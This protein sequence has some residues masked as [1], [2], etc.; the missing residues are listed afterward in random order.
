MKKEEQDEILRDLAKQ[1]PPPP[2]IGKEEL[3][4]ITSCIVDV[5]AIDDQ[6]P[7]MRLGVQLLIGGFMHL[8]D[9]DVI[10]AMAKEAG[11]YSI[12]QFVGTPCVCKETSP[13]C[14]TVAR[15]AIIG[16]D[17]RHVTMT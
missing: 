12:K 2:F 11:I 7:G 15:M 4:V 9:W 17:T 3:G 6:H 14:Y 1:Q 13:K 10:P 5:S 8:V 16:V